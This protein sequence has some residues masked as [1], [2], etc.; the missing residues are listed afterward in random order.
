M[1]LT[2]LP[3]YQTIIDLICVWKRTGT[4]SGPINCVTVIGWM[5]IFI[6]FIACTTP[7]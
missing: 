1:N 4:M 5:I 3:D 2:N 6:G 7:T